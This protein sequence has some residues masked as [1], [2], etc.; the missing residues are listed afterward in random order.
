MDEFYFRQREQSTR[1]FTPLCWTWQTCRRSLPKF[2]LSSFCPNRTQFLFFIQ[3]DGIS[4]FHS[5]ESSMLFIIE[6][7]ENLI[8]FNFLGLM[9]GEL[10]KVRFYSFSSDKILW[11]H[12]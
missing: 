4:C 2:E 10:I 3:E 9:A 1:C 8:A 7:M 12:A 11:P 5:V 6:I